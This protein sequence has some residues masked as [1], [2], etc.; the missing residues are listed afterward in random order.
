[1]TIYSNV[2][3]NVEIR[4]ISTNGNGIFAKKDIKKGENIFT[5]KI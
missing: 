2:P 5:M 1:M 4:D 3:D